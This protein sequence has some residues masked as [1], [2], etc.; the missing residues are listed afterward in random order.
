MTLSAIQRTLLVGMG[1]QHKTVE[2]LAEELGG[3]KVS[4][5]MA[6]F[7]QAVRKFEKAFREIQRDAVADMV[8]DHSTPTFLFLKKSVAC[9]LRAVVRPSKVIFAI[10]F[11]FVRLCP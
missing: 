9:L 6:L 10:P 5:L 1:F 2:E 3:V 4:Q 8:R 7:A 11:A